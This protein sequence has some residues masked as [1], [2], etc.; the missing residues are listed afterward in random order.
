ML[1]E[2]DYNRITP[3]YFHGT[4]YL[5][6]LSKTK[7]VIYLSSTKIKFVLACIHLY[8]HI[9]RQLIQRSNYGGRTLWYSYSYSNKIISII[10][11]M[12]KDTIHWLTNM[13][14]V[15][16]EINKILTSF[17]DLLTLILDF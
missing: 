2:N 9:L 10:H 15:S 3:V 17:N 6:H 7:Y 8:L 14:E 12:H 16:T 13:P 1:F 4:L 11:Q 5:L